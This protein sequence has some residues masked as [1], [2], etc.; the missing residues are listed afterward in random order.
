[1]TTRSRVLTFLGILAFAAL[2]VYNTLTAQKAECFVAVSYQGRT[3]SATASAASRDEAQRQ[4]QT[5]ACGTLATGMN[6]S[7]ACGRTP[8]RAVRCKEL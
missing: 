2:L 1:M 3:D 8:P 6:E 7:I 4:A 5:T